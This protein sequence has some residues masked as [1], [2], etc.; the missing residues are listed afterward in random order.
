MINGNDKK[1]FITSGFQERSKD[2]HTPLIEGNRVAD[3]VKFDS[4]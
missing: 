2:V 4:R 1:Y 3:R